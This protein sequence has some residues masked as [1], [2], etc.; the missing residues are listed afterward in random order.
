[1]IMPAPVLPKELQLQILL[2]KHEAEILATKRAI[3]DRQKSLLK[4]NG[5]NKDLS[6][7]EMFSIPIGIMRGCERIFGRDCWADKVFRMWF[8]NQ[9]PVLKVPIKI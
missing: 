3:Q 7:R 5:A 1:M 4:S 8:V 2:N 6:M 9:C